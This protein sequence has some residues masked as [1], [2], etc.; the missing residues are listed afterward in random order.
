MTEPLPLPVAKS[1]PPYWTAL[2]WGLIGAA[3]IIL[4]SG[5]ALFIFEGN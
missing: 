2:D 5:L 4:I 1:P 3:V